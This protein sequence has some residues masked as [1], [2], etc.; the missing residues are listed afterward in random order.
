MTR[1]QRRLKGPRGR[2]GGTA[3]PRSSICSGEPAASQAGSTAAPGNQ[4]AVHRVEGRAH[5]RRLDRP[6]VVAV[7]TVEEVDDQQARR[8]RRRHRDDEGD[9]GACAAPGG[10]RTAATKPITAT[11]DERAAGPRSI[12][13]RSG[14]PPR[15]APG[16]PARSSVGLREPVLQPRPP[17]RAPAARSRRSRRPCCVS[18]WSTRAARARRPSPA[19]RSSTTARAVAGDVGLQ[20]IRWPAGNRSATWYEAERRERPRRWSSPG[21][22]SS[23]RTRA[24]RRSRRGRRRSSRSR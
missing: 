16:A 13:G 6:L 3:L 19:I 20:L 7:G 17:A 5:R 8:H 18:Q 4:V 2:R 22:S 21:R 10:R 1:Y 24:G 11:P 23:C 15:S 14:A 9:L 12:R